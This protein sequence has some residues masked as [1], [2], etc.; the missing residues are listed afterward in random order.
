MWSSHIVPYPSWLLHWH[1]EVTLKDMGKTGNKQQQNTAN[2]AHSFCNTYP[3]HAIYL[4]IMDQGQTRIIA[5]QKYI[6][7]RHSKFY[8]APVLPHG[9][10]FLKMYALC[11]TALK[12]YPYPLKW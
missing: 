12:S 10:Q 9:L 7:V 3:M 6:F 5:N 8:D 1:W 2:R 4:W 11:V